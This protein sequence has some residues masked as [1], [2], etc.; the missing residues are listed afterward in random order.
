MNCWR[1]RLWHHKADQSELLERQTLAP[2][3]RSNRTAGEADF[4]TTR[5]I[6]VNCW[7][8]RLWHQK[9]GQRISC[10]AKFNCLSLPAAWKSDFV[11]TRQIKVNCWKG[12][13][14]YQKADQSELLERQTLVPKDKLPCNVL[15]LFSLWLMEIE[16]DSDTRR[17]LEEDATLRCSIPFPCLW[18]VSQTRT[19]GDG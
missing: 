8:G 19:P 2:Q 16:S 11:T 3:G 6:K 9:A 4:G 13:L 1:G 5:Q 7:R 14:W 17:E 12:R 10:P 15:D 18:L